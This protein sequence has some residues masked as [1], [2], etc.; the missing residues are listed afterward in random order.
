MT[1]VLRSTGKFD[2]GR[3]GHTHT[4]AH[5]RE[6]DL[7]TEAEIGV[8]WPQAE[9]CWQPLEA[10]RDKELIPVLPWHLQKDLAFA[11]TLF[12]AP[13]RTKLI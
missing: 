3:R 11:N 2:T 4:H 6:G 9:E 12:L 13:N 1:H 8:M 10:R 7:K 5:R